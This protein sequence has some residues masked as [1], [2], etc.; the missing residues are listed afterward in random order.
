MNVWFLL[1]ILVKF[2]LLHILIF[3]WKIYVRYKLT[4]ICLTFSSVMAKLCHT[5]KRLYLFTYYPIPWI[6]DHLIVFHTSLRTF[7]WEVMRVHLCVWPTFPRRNFFLE[8]T[9]LKFSYLLFWNIH[10]FRCLLIFVKNVL[11]IY[12]F[13]QI[14]W[15]YLK[16]GRMYVCG[17]MCVLCVR[18]CV[19]HYWQLSAVWLVNV[20]L[21]KVVWW[22]EIAV[23]WCLVKAKEFLVKVCVLET[24]KLNSRPTTY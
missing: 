14:G 12:F 18:V 1:A 7:W 19:L 13:I 10:V 2:M 4:F 5:V 3:S 21:S 6:L 9:S 11:T 17:R 16:Y 22:L 20:M 23:Q 15:T 8:E 24:W